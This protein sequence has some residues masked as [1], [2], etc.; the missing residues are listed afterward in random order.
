M[1]LIRILH[2]MTLNALKIMSSLRDFL[3]GEKKREIICEKLSF[4]FNRNI[5][6][7][8]ECNFFY[9]DLKCVMIIYACLGAIFVTLQ[10]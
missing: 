9:F 5:L 2:K 8:N 4:F 3:A 7:F 10:E 1:A 6:M